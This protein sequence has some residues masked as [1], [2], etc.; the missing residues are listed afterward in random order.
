MEDMNSDY[1]KIDTAVGA[2]PHVK[3]MDVA[4]LTVTQQVDIKV[5]GIN[6]SKY[7]IIQVFEDSYL[8]PL[9]VSYHLYVLIN[10]TDGT[11]GVTLLVFS[12]FVVY[13][14]KI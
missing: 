3:L 4:M 12:R 5:S 14:V 11:S 7:A 13:G 9:S 1:R 8:L 10:N 6:F 2:N